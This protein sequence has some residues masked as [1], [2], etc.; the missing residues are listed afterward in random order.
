MIYWI[1]MHKH[2][3]FLMLTAQILCNTLDDIDGTY[4]IDTYLTASSFVYFNMCFLLAVMIF[5]HLQSAS[6]LFHL[7]GNV[8]VG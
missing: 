2:L 7:Y 3:N 5:Y 4:F 1:H 8:L 6:F